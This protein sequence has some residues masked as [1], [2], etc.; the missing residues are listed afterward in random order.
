MAEKGKTSK[1]DVKNN[2]DYL[3]LSKAIVNALNEQANAQ[4]KRAQA[5]QAEKNASQEALDMVK[6]RANEFC[7]AIEKYG[8]KGK[9]LWRCSGRADIIKR[10]KKGSQPMYNKG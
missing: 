5:M 2:E 9:I 3:N 10:I 4:A 7:D 6:E 1:Q 8:L